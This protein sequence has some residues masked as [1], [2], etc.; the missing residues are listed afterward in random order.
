M[1]LDLTTLHRQT[2]FISSTTS[3]CHSTDLLTARGVAHLV[4]HGTS[5]S[6][7]YETIPHVRVVLSTVDMVVLRDHDDDDGEIAGVHGTANATGAGAVVTQISDSTVHR[8]TQET[9]TCYIVSPLR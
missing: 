6:T 5:G 9:K 7:S 1:W 4:V 2:W 3:T 8:F